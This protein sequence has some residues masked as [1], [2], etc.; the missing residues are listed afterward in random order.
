MQDLFGEI[1][2][3]DG[4]AMLSGGFD[5]QGLTENNSIKKFL[6]YL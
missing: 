1:L 6:N 5:L 3:R 2:T 4:G